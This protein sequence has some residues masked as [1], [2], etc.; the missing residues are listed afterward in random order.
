MT[1]R[2]NILSLVVIMTLGGAVEALAL[3]HVE[4]RR[5][6]QLLEVAGRVVVTAQDGGL[7][8][9]DRDG[10]LWAIPPEEQVKHTSDDSRSSPTRARN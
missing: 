4:F 3:D 1:Q 8:L 2:R 5:D 7:L 9:L 10:V 6:G